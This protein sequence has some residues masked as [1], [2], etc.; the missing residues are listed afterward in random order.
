VIAWVLL[1]VPKPF[2]T[3]TE[4]AMAVDL[5]RP[6]EVP[7]ETPAQK[8]E[9]EREP[10]KALVIPPRP[11]TVTTASTSLPEVPSSPAKT[12]A[13]KTSAPNAAAPK[14][15]APKAPATK[16]APSDAPA[17][18]QQAAP[19]RQPAQ[20][21]PAPQHSA[22]APTASTAAPSPPPGSAA[23]SPPPVAETSIFDPASI[24]KLMEITPSTPT[25]TVAAG[26]FDA[27]AD[28]GADLSRDEKAA[29]KTHLRKCLRLPAGVDA[30]RPLRIVMR[31][32]LKRDGELAADPML[33]S[34]PAA[35]EGPPMVQAATKAL[36]ACQPYALPIDKYDEWKM[37]DLSLSPRDM[38]GG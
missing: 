12:A 27:A 14:A 30:E 1:G 3:A 7:A 8:P 20:H 24:P 15:A 25:A 19:Q 29:F 9:R 11:T 18:Q 10:E 35:R 31:V 22:A 17:S 6:D 13:P 23:A 38:A 26:G 36:K 28:Q 4:Q 33:V 5:V 32:F 34:A 2:E 16:A 37:L 21:Q